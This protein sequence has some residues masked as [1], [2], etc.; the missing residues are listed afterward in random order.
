VIF[1]HPTQQKSP[2]RRKKMPTQTQTQTLFLPNPTP[3][4][5]SQWDAETRQRVEDGLLPIPPG[6][7]ENSVNLPGWDVTQ[8]R[9]WRDLVAQEARSGATLT[10][11]QHYAKQ[12]GINPPVVEVPEAAA[13]L[14]ELAEWRRQNATECSDKQGEV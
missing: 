3:D 13:I 7:N 9:Q 2:Q 10:T 6:D 11:P 14:T 12:H 4:E 8:Y 5:I 1:G